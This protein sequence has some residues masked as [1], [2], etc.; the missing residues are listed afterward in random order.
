MT[1]MSCDSVCCVCSKAYGAVTDWWRSW[2]MAN[3]LA[4]LCSCR[5][6]TFWT[7][8]MTVNLFSLYLMN[9]ISHTTLGAVGNILR[10]HYKSMK[11]DVSFTWGEH[12]IRVC[13]KCSSCLQQCK[14]CKNQTSFPRVI[15]TDVL[16]RFYESQCI[17]GYRFRWIKMRERLPWSKPTLY[18]HAKPL[19]PNRL[20]S[21]YGGCDAAERE[22]SAGRRSSRRRPAEI[23]DKNK[24]RWTRFVHPQQQQQRQHVRLIGNEW[25][26]NESLCRVLTDCLRTV[27][28]TDWACCCCCYRR[29]RY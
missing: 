7:Y 21:G 28:R 19:L 14:N 5:W 24:G 2:L 27:P 12:I 15:T 25:E 3:T 6:W 17:V 20:T 26:L 10:V 22:R 18:H 9:F 29:R 1:L 8:L 13:V 16:P 23:T 11:C 4:C